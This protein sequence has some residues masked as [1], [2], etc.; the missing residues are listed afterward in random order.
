MIWKTP[1]YKRH[2]VEPAIRTKI[3]HFLHQVVNY[4]GSQRLEINPSVIL[5]NS[6]DFLS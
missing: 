6:A 1:K 4:S 2:F 3:Q 5:Q